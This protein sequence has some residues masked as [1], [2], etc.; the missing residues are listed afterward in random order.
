MNFWGSCKTPTIDGSKYMLII[1]DDFSRKSWI[2]LTRDR[3]EVYQVF[4]SWRKQA[5]LESGQKLKAI[6]SDNAPEFI[7]LSKE[8]EKDGIGIELTMPH[9]PSQNG[10]AERLNRTLITKA[11]AILVAAELP[12]QLWGEAVHVACYLKNLD[13]L[14]PCYT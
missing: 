3:S 14:Q 2:Y 8:L 4:E 6:R 12:S 9:T 10:V 13:H 11:R 1:T 7:K 5:Q